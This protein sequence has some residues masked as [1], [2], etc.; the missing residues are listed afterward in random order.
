MSKSTTIALVAGGVLVCALV[1]FHAGVAYGRWEMLERMHPEHTVG[2]FFPP[3][4]IPEGHGAVGTISSITLPTF[5]LAERDGDDE[6]VETG[7]STIV[8]DAASTTNAQDLQ[9]GEEVIVLGDRA[10]GQTID[11]RLIRVLER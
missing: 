3:S 5:T 8:R 6:T 10:N 1:V 9:K 2:G 7:T 4:F 11:A